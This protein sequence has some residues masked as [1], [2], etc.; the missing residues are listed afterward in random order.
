[1]YA[2]NVDAQDI[3]STTV[4]D[5][6]TITGGYASGG[7]YDYPNNSGGGMLCNTENA[8]HCDPTLSDLVFIGNRANLSGGGLFNDGS[9]SAHGSPIVTNVK[10]I[11]N[12]ASDQA[13]PRVSTPYNPLDPD[14]NLINGMCRG[15][16]MANYAISGWS[17]PVLTDVTFEDNYAETGGGAMVNLAPGGYANAHLTRVTF[18]N[19]STAYY[20]GAMYN[21]ASS[22]GINSLI[23]KNVT[24]NGN[25]AVDGG[26]IYN[27]YSDDLS[28]AT[29][30]N[31]TF[32]GNSASGLGGAFYYRNNRAGWLPQIKNSIFWGDS[33]SEGPEIYIEPYGSGIYGPTFSTSVIQGSGGSGT[34]WITALGTDGG[35]NLDDNPRLGTLL[36]HGGLT[37]TMA[38]LSG[39][40]AIDH[41][42]AC[43]A[44]D[45]RG[46]SRP[47]GAGCD[48][49]A[50][51]GFFFNLPMI[52]K[53]G[54]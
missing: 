53:P 3:T 12:M 39:S 46:V 26:A 22:T 5:G 48:I 44:T 29:Y 18:S 41:G 49:G 25:S 27:F 40:S 32:S 11:D 9:S 1:M 2:N 21:D 38:L 17:E 52:L 47:Q 13:L 20:G 19:N 36:D 51:E 28:A 6:F 14:Q 45:Q 31:V 23:L 10:F 37:L 8:R 4:L 42:L 54:D 15:G 35:G 34:G 7:D 50:F 33:A 43:E 24:F 16:G 30:N